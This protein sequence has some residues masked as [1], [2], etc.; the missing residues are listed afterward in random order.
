VAGVLVVARAVLAM[1]PGRLMLMGTRRGGACGLLE[2]LGPF[3]DV[4]LVVRV[5][6]HRRASAYPVTV[7][8]AFMPPA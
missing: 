7:I 4:L 6:I 8:A 2:A 3:P 1:T 5:L